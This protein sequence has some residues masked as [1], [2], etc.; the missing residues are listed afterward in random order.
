[1]PILTW[2]GLLVYWPAVCIIVVHCAL[3]VYSKDRKNRSFRSMCFLKQTSSL[4]EFLCHEV[5]H[6][7]MNRI[8]IVWQKIWAEFSQHFV[9]AGCHPN[10]RIAML[11]INSLRQLAELF[12]EKEELANFQVISVKVLHLLLTLPFRCWSEPQEYT[13]SCNFWPASDR[14]FSH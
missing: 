8:P 11:S 14:R 6:Y 2:E 5:S 1:M 10:S 3:N 13:L 12:L 7:N 4:S 9:G